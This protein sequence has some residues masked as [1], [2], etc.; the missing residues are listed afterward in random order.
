MQP[1]QEPIVFLSVSEPDFLRIVLFEQSR[2]RTL[3]L[4]G[5]AD[6]ITVGEALNREG[7]LVFELFERLH[8]PGQIG[9][10]GADSV[11]IGVGKMNVLDAIPGIHQGL[12]RIGFFDVHVEEVGE[13]ANKIKPILLKEFRRGRQVIKEISLVAVKW[14]QTAAS[15]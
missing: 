9:M 7:V 15:F 6:R 3:G 5:G 4:F 11:A 2:E 12:A 13:Q 10:A 14:F 1:I 8:D